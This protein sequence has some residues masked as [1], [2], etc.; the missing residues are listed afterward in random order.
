MQFIDE[1]R[2]IV[3]A[4]RGGDGS[5]S[6]N[7]EKYKPRGG[8]DGG[9]GGDGGSVILRATEDLSTLEYLAHRNLVASERGR[10]GS[11]NNRSGERGEDVTIEVPVG[12]MVFD[13]SGLFADLAAP[14]DE[15]TV[16][17][18]GEGGK[19]N[20]SFATSTRQ[21]PKFR[22][23]GLPGE[24]R[25]VRLELRVLSDVGLVGLP[26]AGKSS[27]LAALSAARPRV[28]DYPFTTLTP[29]LGV[30]EERGAPNPYVVADIPGLISGASEGRGLGNRFLRHVARARVLALILDASENPEGAQS[31]LLAELHA[32]RL[33]G[34]PYVTALNKIDLL[35]EE[36]RGYLRETFPG[37]A[38]ISA[39]SGEGVAEF[40]RMLAAKLDEV[41]GSESAEAMP[42]G[43]EHRVYRPTWKGLRIEEEDGVYVILGEELE[44][45]ALK[46]DWGNEE[47]VEYF[48]RELERRGVVTAL[49]RAGAETGDEVRVGETVFD[50]K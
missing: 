37:A 7:R 25:E 48:A 10:H 28:G 43:R 42:D 21:A 50:F 15:V 33:S 38:L 17:R 8:P 45:L 23:R 40:Q 24:E 47:G 2:F 11:G 36:L 29:K 46:T 12:T 32:A 41:R 27:L 3:R 30:V 20:G 39:E 16:A 26:N 19:G 31:T 14:G 5:V 34:K 18:G 49:R 44:R 1:A 4:G 35:D 9:R 22:E 6:F 13:E